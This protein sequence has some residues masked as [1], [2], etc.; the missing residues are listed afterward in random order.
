MPRIFF[1]MSAPLTGN[2]ALNL[3]E[4]Q[5][6]VHEIRLKEEEMPAE[7]FNYEPENESSEVAVT[8][9]ALG[10]ESE[11]TSHFTLEPEEI[12]V[13]GRQLRGKAIVYIRSGEKLGDVS[14]VLFDPQSLRIAALISQHGSLLNRQELAFP[15]EDVV[16]WGKDA[17][18]TKNREP[19]STDETSQLEAYIDLSE[20][21]EGRYVVSTDGVRVGQINDVIID[22]SGRIASYAL[23]QVF[24]KGPVGQSKRIP[25]EATSSLGEDVLIVDRAKFP[26]E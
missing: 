1:Q 19:L 16:I 14:K 7:I 3:T 2:H 17:I 8:R 22:E 13:P 26:S 21:L 24:I 23:S 5:H 11:Q 18:L 25:V 6:I 4:N 20:Q 9:P 12:S 15:A 10:E